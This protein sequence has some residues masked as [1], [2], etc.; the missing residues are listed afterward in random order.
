MHSS[1]VM[2][3]FMQGT[4]WDAQHISE[5]NIYEFD[6]QGW[7]FPCNRPQ[8]DFSQVLRKHQHISNQC[9]S[10]VVLFEDV[11]LFVCTCICMS[12]HK[13]QDMC[14]SQSLFPPCGLWGS[15]SGCQASNKRSS[16]SE[17]PRTV[18]FKVPLKPRH[19]TPGVNPSFSKEGTPL[20]ENADLR[21]LHPWGG[22]E[23]NVTRL[24]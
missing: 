14:G 15:S 7:I 23:P 2:N 10:K 1:R 3:L 4:I 22:R 8:R 9:L 6:D 17:T 11:D 13:Q 20:E 19:F 18:T 16:P 12:V 21:P 24:S 5:K